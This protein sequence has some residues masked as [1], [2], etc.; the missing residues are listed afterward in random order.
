MSNLIEHILNEDYVSA[1]ELFESHMEQ[2][3]QRKLFEAKR[4]MQ[5]EATGGLSAAQM[6]ARK[7]LGW[8]R[9]SD[10]LPDPRDIQL[11]PLSDKKKKLPA[12]KK[13]KLKEDVSRAEVE[14]Q[15]DILKKSGKAQKALSSLS[16][17]MSAKKKAKPETDSGKDL[18]KTFDV[19]RPEDKKRPGIIARNLNT[20]GGRDPGYVSSPKSP[21]QK[22][23]RVGKVL[24]GAAGLVS[25]FGSEVGW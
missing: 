3:A 2:I 1:N 6:Q 15:K 4:M 12:I 23:G 13:K 20:L 10:V 21:E 18:R 11:T 14:K 8:K 25:R 16:S 7:E 9:A 19:E 24:R 5:A 17:L 22:G